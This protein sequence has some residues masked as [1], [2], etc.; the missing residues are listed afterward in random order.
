M[1]GIHDT[2]FVTRE[3]SENPDLTEEEKKQAKIK[4]LEK[5]IKDQQ[6]L[7]HAHASKDDNPQIFIPYK[8]VLSLYDAGLNVS[9]DITLMWV[10]DNFGYMRRYPGNEEQKRKGGN[11][12]YYHASYWGHPAMSY[13]FINSIPLAQ[14]KNELKKAYENGIRQMW[15]LNAGAIKPLETDIEFFLSY[16]WEIDRNEEIIGSISGFIENWINRN[17]EGNYGSL[18]AEIYEEFSQIT[19]VRKLEHMKSN[20]FSQTAYGNEAARRMLRYQDLFEKTVKIHNALKENEKDAFL[21]LFAMKIYAAYFINASFYFADRS[22]LMYELGCMKKADEYT[23][24]SRQMDEHKRRLIY[25]YNKVMSGGKWDKILTPECF[26]PP[27]TALYPACKPA[28]VISGEDVEIVAARRVTTIATDN[29]TGNTTLYKSETGFSE[30]DGYVSMFAHHYE[31]NSGWRE[32]K[33]LGRYEGNLMEADGGELEY[34]FNTV[35]EGEYLLEFYRFPSLNSKGRLRVR[36][37]IDDGEMQILESD[38]ID[39]W[40][41]NWKENVLNYVEKMYLELPNM[42]AGKHKLVV[43]SIDRYVA[44]SK[45]VIYTKGFTESKSGCDFS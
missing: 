34:E 37:S 36:I 19:N 6:D 13:L 30:N 3:I 8:E 5:V 17:F 41:G 12:L 16:A 33:K 23:S 7:I 18:A 2:G 1:R 31:K 27:C 11:G 28:L 4:L 29:I 9:E 15:V 42:T 25:Y 20:V 24:M 44:F 10:N 22:A 43:H 45:I 35:S 40:C 14:T 26:L 38:A 21:Q 32:I 39:E